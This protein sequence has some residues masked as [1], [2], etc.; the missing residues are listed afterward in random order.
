MR[1]RI[2]S[3]VA[4]A[5]RFAEWIDAAPDFERMAPTPF[6]TVCFRYRPAALAATENQPDVA[7]RIDALNT[8]LMDAINRTGKAFVSHTRLNGRM[9]IRVAV[10]NLRTQDSDVA[11]VWQLIQDEAAALSAPT[12]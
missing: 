5:A 12:A 4:M 7:E 3:H 2:E 10:G 6:S 9:T 1:R 8:R 11:L